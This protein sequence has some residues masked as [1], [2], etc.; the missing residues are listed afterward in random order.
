MAKPT[1]VAKNITNQGSAVKDKVK[2]VERDEVSVNLSIGFLTLTATI[3]LLYTLCS[4]IFN[5]YNPDIQ[6]I[7]AKVVPLTIQD[8]S[9][10]SPE[11]VERM[12]YQLSLLFTPIFIFFSYVFINRNRKFLYENQNIAYFINIIGF[13]SFFAYLFTMLG[14]NLVYVLE[15]DS[16]NTF[17][18]NAYFFRD[19]LIGKFNIIILFYFFCAYLFLIFKKTEQTLLI[20]SIVNVICY[21]IVVF[22]LFDIGL[23]NVFHLGIQK[24]DRI[25]ETNAVFYSIT[26]VCAGKTLLVNSNSQYGLYAWMLSPIFNIIGLSTFNMALVMN[27]LNIVSFSLFYLAIKRLIKQDIIS[28]ITFVCLIYWQYWRFR[29]P[30]EETPRFY[31]QYDP[32][33]ILF[34]SIAFFLIVFYQSCST[35]LKKI[36]LPLLTLS[37]SFGV[38]WNSDS[39]I[40]TFGATYVALFISTLDPTIPIKDSIRKSVIYALWMAGSLVFAVSFFY[41]STKT[42]SGSWPELQKFMEFQKIFY[43]SGFF[44]LKMG[45]LQ[46]WN[47]PVIAY[48]IAGIYCVHFIRKKNHQNVPG[49]AYLFILG[50]G[51]F[52]YFQG[53]SYDLNIGAVMYPS[54]ILLGYFCSKFEFAVNGY[55]IR[56]H[57]SI[58]FFIVPFIFLADGFFSVLFYAPSV[59]SY[60]VTNAFTIDQ[61]KE[62]SIKVRMDFIKKH[63]HEKDTVIILAKDY[64]GYFYASGKYYNP[65]DLPGSTEVFF[66]SEIF[67]LLEI[68]KTS[69][70]PI[71]FDAS[72]PW[73]KSDTIVKTL[74]E[75]TEITDQLPDLSLVYLKH[76]NKIKPSLSP[77]QNTVYFDYLG[78]YR[79]YINPSTKLNL[80]ESFSVEM[81]ISLDSGKMK[82][83]EFVFTNAN[84]NSP[85]SG[86]Y[87][88]QYGDALNQFVF[89]FWNGACTGPLFKLNYKEKNH[90]LIKVEKNVITV[91]NNGTQIAQTASNCTIKNS[92]G[93]F[94]IYAFFPG[95]ISEIKIENL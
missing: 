92:D 5:N 53:R 10:F 73:L 60:A 35:N 47:L 75:Y 78:D 94:F 79:K 91:F 83:D 9:S 67:S 59:H 84:N 4:I 90:L 58:L 71:I 51:I 65:I 29:I 18:T 54:I 43:V 38:L 13:I 45:L 89:S 17:A 44:M 95:K 68:L 23:Y 28:L 61:R 50:L 1:K 22:L 26:Q 87:M 57:E 37:V 81:F 42:H 30:M 49:I 16:T 69:R 76:V 34:P 24:W 25:M 19:T 3:L 27:C 14:T 46:F 66:K 41:I 93:M 80:H 88:R 70:F 55:K 62:D 6:S 82:K 12:Q 8:P 56:F 21:S 31:F 20:K 11:P 52:A 33:R 40:V 77:D 36:I 15:P 86:I 74:S 72:H 2:F 7:L 48:L 85:N 32:I 63:V 39:G 64:D